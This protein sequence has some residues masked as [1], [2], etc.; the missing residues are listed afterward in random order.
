[1]INYNVLLLN[2]DYTPFKIVDWQT[3]ISYTYVRNNVTPLDFYD[4]ELTDGKG[5]KYP[6]PAVIVKNR[7]V[8]RIKNPLKWTRKK[9][10]SRDKYT[11]VYCGDK[12]KITIDHLL[13]KSR[14][15]LNTFSNTVACCRYCN[16]YKANRTPEEAGLRLLTTPKI[17]TVFET[18]IGKVSELPKQW[19]NYLC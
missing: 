10:L 12:R 4:F 9:V 16:Y 11:C 17:P 6:I 7:Y 18:L 15:G 19:E 5:R 3:A 8:Q 2:A 1:M 13:P 14:G